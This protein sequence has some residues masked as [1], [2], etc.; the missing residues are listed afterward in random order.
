MRLSFRLILFLVVGITLVTFL[1]ARNQ[2]RSEESGLRTDLERRAAV[3][4]ESLQE[5]VEPALDKGSHEQLQRI[6][7]R[8]GNR[9]RLVGVAIY[10]PHG[11][12]LAQSSTLTHGFDPPPAPPSSVLNANAGVGEF[13]QLNGKL[14]HIYYLQLHNG[15]SIVG[16][17]ADLS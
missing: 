8:F 11:E 3:L 5:I 9:E 15:S 2:V 14:M 16:V 7:D 17:L 1:V 10:D 6:V 13:V 12:V 4:A